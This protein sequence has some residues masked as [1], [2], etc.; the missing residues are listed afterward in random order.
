PH[1]R[2]GPRAFP[3]GGR[4]GRPRHSRAA[5]ALVFVLLRGAGRGD[6][7]TRPAPPPFS[8]P[9]LL[10]PLRL[11]LPAPRAPPLPS[12]PRLRF[13]VGRGHLR[14]APRRRGALRRPRGRAPRLG[15][16]RPWPLRPPRPSLAPGCPRDPPPPR[17][18]RPR[19]GARPRR[20]LP[21]LLRPLHGRCGRDPR[22]RR[23]PR[24]RPPRLSGNRRDGVGFR[25]EKSRSNF[26]QRWA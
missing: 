8:A 24:A 1:S 6:A 3:G 15:P 19:P 13:P 20:G 18:R 7:A 5:G 2:R 22:T 25:K 10:V 9:G 21:P 14:P 26:F 11:L 16:R 4:S 12:R 17:R 23:S